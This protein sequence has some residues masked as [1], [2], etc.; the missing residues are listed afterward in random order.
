[1]CALGEEVL[2]ARYL[3]FNQD[4]GKQLKRKGKRETRES[5]HALS[6]LLTEVQVLLFELQNKFY[7]FVRVC[8][9]VCI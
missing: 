7:I 3:L 1:M 4:L 9:C 8:V 6:K 2:P 5:G